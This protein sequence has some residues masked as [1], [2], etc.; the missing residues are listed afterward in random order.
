MGASFT[1]RK[2]PISPSSA[3]RSPMPPRVSA[4]GPAVKYL[5]ARFGPLRSALVAD[6]GEDGGQRGQHFLQAPPNARDVRVGLQRDLAPR[7]LSDELVTGGR[8]QQR[9][10][11]L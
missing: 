8:H 2:A 3:E 1:T 4:N 5:A 11:D 10:V 9:R 6:R 7:H